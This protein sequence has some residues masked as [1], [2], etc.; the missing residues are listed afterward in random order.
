MVVGQLLHFPPLRDDVGSQLVSAL[1]AQLLDLS[2]VRVAVNAEVVKEHVHLEVLRYHLAL[3]L[4]DVFG[5]QLHLARTD[6]VAVL[7]ER[8]V[9]HHAA[10]GI[11]LPRVAVVSEFNL[12]VPTKSK[13]HSLLLTQREVRCRVLA[14]L[15]DSG[16]WEREHL[17][18]D[19]T[20]AVVDVEE[21]H[22]AAVLD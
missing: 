19:H 17:V 18:D 21:G 9:E 5:R 14:P 15:V 16:V 10:E 8:C 3:V 4:A 6:V 20:L 22:A 7:D 11:R 1:L 12:D 13:A 2:A